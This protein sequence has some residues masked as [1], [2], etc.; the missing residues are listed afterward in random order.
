MNCNEFQKWLAG[1]NSNEG[2][3]R[4][5]DDCGVHLQQCGTCQGAVKEARNYFTLMQNA[6]TPEMEDAFW[7]NYLS[8]VSTRVSAETRTGKLHEIPV[9]LRG[10]IIPAAAAVIL[11][12]G[13]LLTDRYYPV[14]DYVLSDDDAYTSSLDFMWAEHEQAL[15]HH[16]FDP[17]PLYAVEEVIP[18]NWEIVDRQDPV[19][20]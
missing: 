9:W 2:L 15:S 19:K 18:E 1:Q 4:M 16:M 6:R 17:T 13:V 3:N 14:L 8:T 20:K 10:L 7:D 12:T 5:P 11:I